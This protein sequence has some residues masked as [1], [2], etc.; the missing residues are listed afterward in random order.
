MAKKKCDE[1]EVNDAE[2]LFVNGEEKSY[3]CEPSL[4]DMLF[5]LVT[6]NDRIAFRSEEKDAAT[7][8]PII[9]IV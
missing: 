4:K 5:E 1:C 7:K 6:Q 2:F 3:L 8:L 9:Q